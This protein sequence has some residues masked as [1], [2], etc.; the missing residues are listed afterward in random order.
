MTLGPARLHWESHGDPEDPAVVLIAGLAQQLTMWP[1][2]FVQAIVVGGYRVVRFDNRDIGL[3][4]RTAGGKVR[5][6]DVRFGDPATAPYTIE[7]MADDTIRMLDEVGIERTHLV[8]YSMGGMIAQTVAVR[9]AKRVLS[10]VSL[11]STTGAATVGQ[12]SAAGHD[13][14]YRPLPADRTAAIARLVD[15]VRGWSTPG[16]FDPDLTA[17]RIRH[18]YDRGYDTA[19]VGRQYAAIR[20]S[21]DRTLQLHRVATPT[22]VVH[23]TIDP[24]IDVS[25]GRATAA[26]IPGARYVELAGLGHDLAPSRWPEI[27]QPMHDLWREVAGAAD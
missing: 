24:I 25:G 14:L 4:E 27:L 13:I 18:E 1:M 8:G 17:A 21:G 6:A 15:N 22:L 2:G 23:G 26:A 3:A 12:A 9:F 10:L 20:S 16:E 11:M 7:T 5:L 19:G